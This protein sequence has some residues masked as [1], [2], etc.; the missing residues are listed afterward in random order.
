[1]PRNRTKNSDTIIKEIDDRLNKLNERM[2]VLR[3]RLT[4]VDGELEEVTF[5]FDSLV[6]A[7]RAL[8]GGPT[9]EPEWESPVELIADDGA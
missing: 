1:M 8:A 7:K 9:P 2:H 4:K 5:E 3:E 6:K